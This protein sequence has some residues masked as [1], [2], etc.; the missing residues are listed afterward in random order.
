MVSDYLRARGYEVTVARNGHLALE[1]AFDTRPDIIL[2]DGY[3]PGLNGI[4]AIKVLRDHPITAPVPILAVTAHAM[5]GDREKMLEAGAT[6]YLS[7][8]FTLRAL[9]AK[10]A[11]MLQP[12]LSHHPE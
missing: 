10:V 1:Y 8:P 6:D 5:A 9:S 7:K 11:Q 4:D 3:M 2:M 12:K